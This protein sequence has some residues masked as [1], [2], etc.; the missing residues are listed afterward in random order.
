MRSIPLFLLA[1]LLAAQ[2]AAA[3]PAPADPPA[4]THDI[5][6]GDYFGIIG[7]GSL[8]VSPDGAWIAHTESRWGTGKEGRDT[9]L[10]VVSRDGKVRRRLTFD[11][12]G[13]GGVAWG[14]DGRE[15]WFLAKDD[16]GREDPPRD[17]SRQVWRITATGGEPV[18][19]TRADDGVLDFVLTPDGRT[20]YYRTAKDHSDEDTWQELRG[21]YKDLEYG[22]GERSLHAVRKLDLAN[23][24]DEEVLAADRVIWEMALSPDGRQ[25]ALITTEDNELIFMEGWSQVEV[26][27][28]QGG[29]LAAV[30]PSGWRDDHPSPYGWLGDLAWSADSRA[31]AFAV[32]YDGYATRLYAAERGTTGWELWVVPR[33][34]PVYYDGGLVWRGTGRTL[35][36]RGES[37]ARVRVHQVADVKA[38]G[39]GQTS[40]VADGDGVVLDF[41][42]DRKGGSPAVILETLTAM[43]DVYAVAGADKLHRLTNVNPQ[44]DTWKLPQIRHVSWTGGD[45]DTVWGILELP[46]AYRDGDGPLPAVVELHGGPTASTKHHLRFWIYGRALL[47]CKGYALLS[48]NYHG[49]TGYGD[50]FLEKLIGRENEIE[51]ADIAAGTR[52]LIDQGIADPA[53]IGVMGWSNGGY[54]TNCMIV[55]EP[56]LYAAASSGAGVLDMVIQWGIEDT[57]GH[58][59]NFVEGLPWEVPDHYRSASPLFVLDRVRTPTLIHVGG[60]DPRV[61]PAHSRALYRALHHYLQVPTHL[62]VYPGEPHGLTTHENRLAKMEWDLAWFG[63]YLGAPDEAAGKD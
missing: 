59:I 35:C 53:R 18:P 28:L 19:V 7:L 9:D 43:N 60:N 48:P 62:V 15:I 6:P 34:H 51:V 38:G 39:Q 50:A 45:G 1:A 17:G 54:L 63:K 25:L 11:G 27:D 20:L 40:L 37:M 42:F 5:E 32:S 49:S 3:A 2:P 44:V 47:P 12:L 36:Y 8:A 14:P 24:R 16:A 4:R 57:P 30:T 31:L 46:P 56:D 58:V 21:K 61:P 23:W 13:A 10:W 41:G 33:P 29:T 22:H 55:A 52:W 26:L